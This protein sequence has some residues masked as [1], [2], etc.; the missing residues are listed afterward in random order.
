VG[1]LHD[2]PPVEPA[3]RRQLLGGGDERL[4]AE[5]RGGSETAFAAI[6]QRHERALRG[7]AAKLLRGSGQDPEDVVQDVFIRAHAALTSGDEREL[8][9]KPWLFRMTR[10][11]AI[12]ALRAKSGSAL[13]LDAEHAAEPVA[14]PATDPAHAFGRREG[15]RAVLADLA[16]LPEQQR[17]AL[18]MR[19]LEGLSHEAVAAQL[20][21]TPQATRQ[22]VLRA[23]D[24]LVKAAAA[25][26]AAC[27]DIRG[28]LAGAHDARHRPSEHARRHVRG[29]AACRSYRRQLHDVRRRVALVH[30]GPAILGL[31]G[32][33]KL[34][35]AGVM[36]GGGKTAAVL[37]TATV[38][39]TAGAAGVV[40]T[41]HR[42]LGAG[43]PAPRVVPG[44][45]NLFAQKIVRGGRLP[46]DTALVDAT[47]R[48][49]PVKRLTVTKLRLTCPR[50]YL[51]VA[52]VPRERDG[53]NPAFRGTGLA[54]PRQLDRSRFV[55]FVVRT[56]P[57]IPAR[58]AAV[59][60]GLL[61][62]KPPLGKRRSIDDL[63][64]PP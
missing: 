42:T 8:A 55:D 22:L 63:V 2:L 59:R 58:T 9:L 3:R 12:D 52:Y 57:T 30:P 5:A 20:G 14:A 35:S 39:V 18:R 38:A 33:A 56:I 4:V 46:A 62:E 23:R 17:D 32:L 6:V 31:L 47:V 26:D 60:T 54:D 61:C 43:E 44:S 34:G 40:L 64:P 11:R 21:V 13:S 15:L 49:P 25:R 24:N 48:V 51:A 1:T 37:A 45:S 50:G 53:R 28:D 29:C 19:E 16:E 41:E 10:N 27:L 36:A 7:Y